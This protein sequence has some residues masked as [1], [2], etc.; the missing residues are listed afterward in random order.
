MCSPYE[1]RCARPPT[2]L[3]WSQLFLS[4]GLSTG[5]DTSARGLRY[6]SARHFELIRIAHELLAVF[7]IRPGSRDTACD[8]PGAATRWLGEAELAWRRHWPGSGCRRA[9]D[10]GL[11]DLPYLPR[12]P[13]Q[14]L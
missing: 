10:R 3:L 1:V 5:G 9:V 7:G 14:T 2:S 4:Q 11:L 6:C 12:G 8:T 13:N